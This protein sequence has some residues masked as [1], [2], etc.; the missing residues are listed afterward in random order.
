MHNLFIDFQ[1]AY[2]NV[3]RKETWSE[4]HKGGFPQNLVKLCRILNNEIYA[5]IKID[6]HLSSKF[7][8]DNV[9]T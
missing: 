9:L 4:I 1:A 8:V 5:K 3:W 7:K 2:D 6:N